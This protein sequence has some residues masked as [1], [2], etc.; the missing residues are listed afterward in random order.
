M[1]MITSNT[2]HSRSFPEISRSFISNFPPG[3]V[4]MTSLTLN[5]F[6][7]PKRQ[8][9]GS[10]ASFPGSQPPPTPS[11]DA[12]TQP[13]N[14]G[15]PMNNYFN[16]VGSCASYFRNVIQSRNACFAAGKYSHQNICS[17]TCRI[18]LFGVNRKSRWDCCCCMSDFSNQ[19]FDSF[20][21]HPLCY[22]HNRVQLRINI[23][24]LVPPQLDALCCANHPTYHLF[25]HFPLAFA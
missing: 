1:P 24:L 14:L 6:G 15:S 19:F 11:T 25:Y 2:I 7:H 17:F 9:V 4:G 13:R 5:F 10:G 12:D 18:L 3:F 16:V 21:W 22:A 20:E 23:T 8:I